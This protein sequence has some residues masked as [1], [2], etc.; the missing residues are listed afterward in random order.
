MCFYFFSTL[1]IRFWT[2]PPN[3]D[4]L[5]QTPYTPYSQLVSPLSKATCYFVKTRHSL[6]CFSWHGKQIKKS[7]CFFFKK[8]GK[9]KNT[10]YTP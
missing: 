3:T 4:F 2:M 5:I 9:K 6:S 1:S 10:H 8:K 7:W